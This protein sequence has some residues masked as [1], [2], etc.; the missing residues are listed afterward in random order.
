MYTPNRKSPPHEL[1]WCVSRLPQRGSM[2]ATTGT[3]V[4]TPH[5]PVRHG[6]AGLFDVAWRAQL[7]GQFHLWRHW[8]L[9]MRGHSWRHAVSTGYQGMAARCVHG[10]YI[11]QIS[12]LMANGKS[13]YRNR[14]ML[15]DIHDTY[16]CY[17]HCTSYDMHL[18]Q[19]SSMY[20]KRPATSPPAVRTYHTGTW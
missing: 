18:V 2:K 19:V 3:A 15:S 12:Y 16:I 5:P 8:S 4:V 17:V 13:E 7:R 11:Q 20:A 1:V 10:Q 14:C 6:H 9:F